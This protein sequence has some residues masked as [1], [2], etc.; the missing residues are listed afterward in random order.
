MVG[1]LAI[2]GIILFL[3][4]RARR[5]RP[6]HSDGFPPDGWKKSGEQA[7]HHSSAVNEL[8]TEG[9]GMPE[10]SG[11]QEAELRGEGAAWELPTER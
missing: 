5:S 4:K 8:G 6:V 7:H 11:R 1:A 9:P 3:W 2:L 10:L